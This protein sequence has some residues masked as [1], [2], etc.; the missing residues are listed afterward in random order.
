M[1]NKPAF[2]KD[3]NTRASASIDIRVQ[4]ARQAGAWSGT[5]VQIFCYADWSPQFPAG[6]TAT[7]TATLYDSNGIVVISGN[8]A[9]K[10]I[11][12]GSNYSTGMPGTLVGTITITYSVSGTATISLN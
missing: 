2:G 8:P 9:T 3:N 12:P 10:T 5:S 7:L 4:D 1:N 6:G 11:T